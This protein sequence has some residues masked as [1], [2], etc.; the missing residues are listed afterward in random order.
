MSSLDPKVGDRIVLREGKDN[1]LVSFTPYG[2][3]IL[4][5][6][7]GLRPGYAEVLSIEEKEKYFIAKVKNV[8]EDVYPYIGYEEF[9]NVLET[10]GF[11]LGYDITFKYET[12]S[13][14]R[15]DGE[16]IEE[17]RTEHQIL[18][19]RLDTGL[20]VVAETWEEG[21]SFNTI[22][23]YMPG[24]NG[25]RML[26]GHGRMR[27]AFTGNATMAEFDL[28]GTDCIGLASFVEYARK[29]Q[30]TNIW[31]E[32]NT[33]NLWNYAESDRDYPST[34][35]GNM[36]GKEGY[37]LWNGT[38]SRILLAPEEIEQLFTNKQMKEVFSKR[39]SKDRVS[40]P[41]S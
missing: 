9:L 16:V 34:V 19:Y 41:M 25:V 12:Y 1:R 31:S 23:V 8:V 7:K 35:Y 3:V 24:V 22:R 29:L 11:T 5:N 26:L 30:K 18:A 14:V 20:V 21:K 32:D 2:K 38:I 37:G 28:A 40:I 27:C 13:N 33:P 15:Q 10:Q 17:V 4:L 39:N 36:W 6:G